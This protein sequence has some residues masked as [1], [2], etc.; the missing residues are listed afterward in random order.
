MIANDNPEPSSQI[1]F[2]NMFK[3]DNL[4]WEQ[5]Y[6]LPRKVTIDSY[7]RCFQYKIINNIL[8][9]NKKLFCFNLTNSPFCSFCS[10]NEETTI[11]IFYECEKVRI[12]WSD[13]KLYLPQLSLPDLSPQ[14]AL[15]GF[16]EDSENELFIL[17]KHILLPFKLYV[18]KDRENKNLSVQGLV[19][20]IIET[21][22]IERKIAIKNNKIEKFNK[23]WRPI[24]R[25]LLF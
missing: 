2:K 5:I 16:Y 23:K 4:P 25:H 9:L 1:Y 21:K 14:T 19:S 17:S 20:M 15:F 24:E 11:H 22:K 8:F 13:L 6:L 10:K 3:T 7:L 12:L 18:Y